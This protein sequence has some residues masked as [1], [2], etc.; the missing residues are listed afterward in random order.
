MSDT[1]LS[2]FR[3]FGLVQTVPPTDEPLTLD[4]AKA[5][6]RVDTG[7]DDDLI[8]DL[9]SAAREYAENST[10]R[11]LMTATWQLTQDRFPGGDPWWGPWW[12]WGNAGVI[13]LPWPPLQ[14]VVSIQYVDTQGNT[15]SVD[16]T[17]DTII[18]S[19]R[20]PARITPA[21]G[22][23]WPVIRPMPNAVTITYVA[24]YADATL[25][26]RQVRLAMKLLIAEWYDNRGAIGQSLEA[27][28]RLLWQ[29]WTGEQER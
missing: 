26:P 7:A 2:T 6:A 5:S 16:L 8:A 17:N 9:I 23:V 10:Q 4:E 27:A 28:D 14:N 12:H 21:W 1:Y 29:C 24:G 22:K 18:D 13:R 19:T 15:Q 25:I 3:G 20:E 11:Q